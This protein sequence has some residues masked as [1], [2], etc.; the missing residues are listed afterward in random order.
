M[1]QSNSVIDAKDGS[2][3]C[4]WPD[5]QEWTAVL[6]NSPGY[7]VLG[8]ISRFRHHN[9]I[10]AKHD[11]ETD[12]KKKAKLAKSLSEKVG[13]R[14]VLIRHIKPLNL[15]NLQTRDIWIAR[16]HF[17]HKY[18][19]DSPTA[20][21]LSKPISQSTAKEC[22]IGIL[23]Y[24]KANVY[25]KE[26]RMYFVAPV[27]T[28]SEVEKL[29]KKLRQADISSSV[30]RDVRQ[31]RR[32]ESLV[33]YST[34]SKISSI[35]NNVT[36]EDTGMHVTDYI[37]SVTQLV[38]KLEAIVKPAVQ[39]MDSNYVRKGNELN[40]L[41]SENIHYTNICRLLSEYHHCT[42]EIPLPLSQKSC[43]YSEKLVLPVLDQDFIAYGTIFT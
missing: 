27:V 6:Q 30:T 33:E 13:F 9:N 8:K 40:I 34:P 4:S 28:R 7:E 39:A 17:P 11:T 37:A 23:P 10:V 12:T 3:C 14:K 35:S 42:E 24:D 31:L 16:H 18:I 5:C 38:A 15:K 21:Y 19:L 2:C 22:N 1:Q 29:V 41:L 20:R 32:N 25:C 36:P 43:I 26:T